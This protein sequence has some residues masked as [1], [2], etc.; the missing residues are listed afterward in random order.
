MQ[1]IYDNKIGLQIVQCKTCLA[2]PIKVIQEVEKQKKRK[3]RS[4]TGCK[5]E[6]FDTVGKRNNGPLTLFLYLK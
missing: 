2:L 3:A 4:K 6:V 1:F 5:Q